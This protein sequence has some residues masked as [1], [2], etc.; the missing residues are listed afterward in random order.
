MLG[1]V[2]RKMIATIFSCA[3]FF[4]I[5]SMLTSFIKFNHDNFTSGVQ[6]KGLVQPISSND[7]SFYDIP[8]NV[9]PKISKDLDMVF[10]NFKNYDLYYYKQG[11]IEYVV[12]DTLDPSNID[13]N[14]DIFEL[15]LILNPSLYDFYDNLYLNNQKFV[16]EM[17][18]IE[19]NI[20]EQTFFI[21]NHNQYK[22]LLGLSKPLSKNDSAYSRIVSALNVESNFKAQQDNKHTIKPNYVADTTDAVHRQAVL[23]DYLK[24]VDLIDTTELYLYENSGTTKVYSTDDTIVN[25][26]PKNQ[27][28]TNGVNYKI[29]SEWGYLINTYNN[30]SEDKISSVIIFDIIQDKANAYTAER[31]TI[32]TVL[33]RNY[34]YY[35]KNNVVFSSVNNNYAIANPNLTLGLSYINSEDNL[36]SKHHPNKGDNDYSLDSDNGFAFS[37]FAAKFVGVGKNSDNSI[38]NISKLVSIIGNLV[39][40]FIP[41][42]YKSLGEL[43][44]D[45]GETILSTVSQTAEQQKEYDLYAED[46]NGKYIRD[47]S[48]ISDFADFNAAKGQIYGLNKQFE[49][50]MKDYVNNE[51][52]LRNS[53]LLFKDTTDSINYKVQIISSELEDDYLAI[54]SHRLQLEVFN[55]DTWLFKQSPEFINEIKGDWSYLLGENVNITSKEVSPSFSKYYAAFG[56]KFDQEFV[57]KPTETGIYDLYLYNTPAFTKMSVDNDIVSAGSTA[58]TDIW[59]NSIFFRPNEPILKITKTFNAGQTYNIKIYTT[60]SLNKRVFGDSYLRVFMSN[61][62]L[63]TSPIANTTYGSLNRISKSI[64]N[65]FANN[66][67]FT[68]PVSGQYSIVGANSF[69]SE[70]DTEVLLLDSNFQEISSNSDGW[71]TITGGIQAYLIENTTYYVVA[72]PTIGSSCDLNIY[73]QVFIPSFNG[74][75]LSLPLFVPRFNNNMYFVTSQNTT[76]MLKFT[77]Q[78]SSTIYDLPIVGMSIRSGGYHL[79]RTARNILEDPVSFTFK[80]NQ[81]YIINFS[82]YGD[83]LPADLYVY[84]EELII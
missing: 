31:T 16:I 36:N 54:I 63:E 59:N 77:A 73:R 9:N 50:R 51:N 42:P 11:L 58:C 75:Q 7:S 25:L 26:I 67:Q 40:Q 64:Y 3:I 22:Q 71:G 33:T 79:E 30:G 48:Y 44:L 32:K 18:K 57:F 29:G 47:L 15:K 46:A 34:R 37:S 28:T 12:A 5:C 43:A 8:T 82:H 56:T 70:K 69:S 65:S 60:D 13:K 27:F 45:I 41:A 17:L 72:G 1:S 66:F 39:L 35:R 52:A 19:S 68:A 49:I 55:D 84:V 24:H 6:K 2:K 78:L 83:V 76:R 10:S 53:P 23:D 61:D 4:T 14:N 81:L 74:N 80:S 21:P 38:E 62:P 20:L